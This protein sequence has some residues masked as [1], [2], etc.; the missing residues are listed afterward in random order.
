MSGSGPESPASGFEDLNSGDTDLILF[1]YAAVDSNGNIDAAD[2][3]ITVNGVD[4]LIV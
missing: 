1:T 3:V 2:V 4:D